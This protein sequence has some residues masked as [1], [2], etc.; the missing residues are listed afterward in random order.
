MLLVV[1]TMAIPRLRTSPEV[2]ELSGML[3]DFQAALAAETRSDPFKRR[4][5]MNWGR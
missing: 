5:C 4:R 2:E 1:L 3:R